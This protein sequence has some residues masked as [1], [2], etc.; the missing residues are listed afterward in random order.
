MSKKKELTSIAK[1][2]SEIKK[3]QYKLFLQEKNEQYNCSHKTHKGALRIKA[4]KV[5]GVFKCRECGTKMDFRPIANKSA[6]DIKSDIKAWRKLGHTYANLA[7]LQADYG[8]RDI[9][10]KIAKF[11]GSL[12]FTAKVFK[13]LFVKGVGK[14]FKQK[15]KNKYKNNLRVSGGGASLFRHRK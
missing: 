10:K 3:G 5:E 7:K 1:A 2:L 11:Q 12:D 6:K 14:T 13:V 15:N 4:T 9:I 8:D